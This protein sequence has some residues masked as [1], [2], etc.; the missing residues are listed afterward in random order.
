MRAV[1]LVFDFQGFIRRPDVE[2]GRFTQSFVGF[3]IWSV[4]RV[5]PKCFPEEGESC[6]Q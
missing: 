4:P 3:F 2:M 1:L 6:G 5:S